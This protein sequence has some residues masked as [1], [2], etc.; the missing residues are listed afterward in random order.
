MRGE[1]ETE[2]VVVVVVVVASVF[3]LVLPVGPGSGGGCARVG[4][5]GGGSNGV[6]YGVRGFGARVEIASGWS[7]VGIG[8]MGD[9]S[10]PLRR[11]GN[12][13][14]ELSCKI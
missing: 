10:I 2:R 11:D 8:K 13:T 6:I 1:V 9:I 14:V 7:V 4:G 3:V 5:G 12:R